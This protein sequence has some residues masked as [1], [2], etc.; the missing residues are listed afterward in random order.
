MVVY[1][2]KAPCSGAFFVFLSW[3]F[4]FPS[5]GLAAECRTP[6]A[7]ESY[8]VA[9]VI[10]GDT[11]RLTNGENVRLIGI[12]T[13]ELGYPG[14]PD[15]PFAREAKATLE[16][17]VESSGR[18][19]GL[20]PGADGRDRY[21]RLLAHL[22]STDGMS[23]TAELLR[24][25][26]GYHAVVAP[27]LAYLDCYRAAEREAR[28]A[29]LGLWRMPLRDGADVKSDETGFHLLQGKVERIGHSRNA[30]WLNLV[31]GI[32]IKIPPAIW[33]EMTAEQ[34]ENFTGR[35]LEVR[36]WFYQHKGRLSLN[37]SHPAAL[38]WL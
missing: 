15:R 14:S 25:G 28:G 11:L 18:R 2:R 6:G 31:G 17:L 9:F 38:R 24:Q 27:N 10:D 33:R 4:L 35:R 13:P 22:Y 21:R 5:L 16:R 29:A 7:V 8:E 32:S 37:L 30:V 36:G 12:D 23:L 3:L 20:Q 1:L 19:L 26:M 34:A